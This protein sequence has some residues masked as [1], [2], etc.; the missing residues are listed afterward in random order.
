MLFIALLLP[1]GERSVRA[2]VNPTYVDDSP[3]ARQ[4]FQQAEEQVGSNVA[5]AVRSYQELLD[6]FGLRLLPAAARDGGSSDEFTSV[7]A[8]V[9]EILTHPQNRQ[10][11]ERY[12]TLESPQAERLL[13]A[14]QL[15]RLALTRPLTTPGLEAMLQLAQRELEAGRFHLARHHL[16]SAIEH[17]ELASTAE[18]ARRRAAHAWYM[19]GVASHYLRDTDQAEEAASELALIGDAEGLSAHLLEELGRL[20]ETDLPQE[21]TSVS[22][23]DVAPEADLG[24]LIAETIWSF[25][26]SEGLASRIET[27]ASSGSGRYSPR[28]APLLSDEGWTTTSAPTVVGDVVYVNQGHT[29][30]ALDRFTG[31]RIWSHDYIDRATPMI[32]DNEA[33]PPMDVNVVAVSGDSLVTLTGHAHTNMRSSDGRVICLD[34]QTGKLRWAARLDRLANASVAHDFAVDELEGLFPHGAPVIIDDIVL[35]E[36]RRVSRQALTSAYVVALDLR[37]GE[38]R[39]IRHIVSSGSIRR[40]ARPFSTLIFAPGEPASIIMA[41]AIGAVASIE[42]NSGEINWLHRYSVPLNPPVLEQSRKPW[43]LATPLVTHDHVIAIHAGHRRVGIYDRTTGG[44]LHQL[45]ASRQDTWNS[46]AYLLGDEQWVYAIGREIHAFRLGDFDSPAWVLQGTGT[47]DED[48]QLRG[49]VQLA[50]SALIVPIADSVL[51]VDRYTGEVEHHLPLPRE[52]VTGNPVAM[53]R[54]LVIAGSR[55][56]GAF[57]SLRE[58]ERMLRERIA[59]SPTSPDPALSLAQLALRADD[60]ALCMEAARMVTKSIELAGSRLSV[61]EAEHAADR[62]VDILLELDAKN[63]AAN[64]ADIDQL[65]AAIRSAARTPQHHLVHRLA[66]GDRLLSRSEVMRALDA[67]QEVLSNPALATELVSE[68]AIIRPGRDW[69]LQRIAQ[70]IAS[71]AN[72][73]EPYAALARDRLAE[74][75]RANAEVDGLLALAREYPFS[76]S[77]ADALLS[78]SQLLADQDQPQRALSVLRTLPEPAAPP[79]NLS[80]LDGA[81]QRGPHARLL[82]QYTALAEEL[83]LD[84]RAAAARASMN[85]SVGGASPRL[86]RIGP[87][88]GEAQLLTGRL[89]TT[90]AAARADSIRPA[91][92]LALILNPE[93]SEITMHGPGSRSDGIEELWRVQLSDSEPMLVRFDEDAVLMVLSAGNTMADTFA[94]MLD[95]ATGDERWRTPHL[96][97]VFDDV[98][99]WPPSRGRASQDG[100]DSDSSQVTTLADESVLVLATPTGHAAGF[101]IASGSLRWQAKLPLEQL[102]HAQLRG[103]LLA[104]TGSARDSRNRSIHALLALDAA[105]GAPILPRPLSLGESRSAGAIWMELDAN[106]QVIYGTSEGIHSVNLWRGEH[107]WINTWAEVGGSPRGWLRGD[108]LLFENGF[109]E[110]QTLDVRTG[111]PDEAF[112]LPDRDVL[113]RD[114]LMSAE[115]VGEGPRDVLAH[116]RQRIVRFGLDGSVRGADVVRDERNF[117]WL[118]HGRAGTEFDG[119]AVND[120]VLVLI[121]ALQPTQGM[122]A[123]P[124]SQRLGRRTQHPYRIYLLSENARI[125]GEPI[126]LPPLPEPIREARLIDGWLLLSLSESSIAA[127]MPL[128]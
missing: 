15:D 49:R 104:L 112:E 125:L 107:D 48:F 61:N 12:R 4:L 17:P 42:P 25:D 115:L 92:N 87:P 11:L 124:G 64:G 84:A 44:L 21:R 88:A 28:S 66:Y 40:A 111:Q 53:E 2:Q 78:A 121:N 58:A 30:T 75:R 6:D 102:H 81:E 50:E 5:E 69:A 71:A 77:A 26:L 80:A 60:F 1:I 103:G 72:A 120:E 97:E 79:P 94:I 101:H 116:Y 37:S 27:L 118:L 16:R 31:V 8:A 70:V 43:E 106:G 56:L 7:R 59:A 108:R 45:D 34:A 109:K 62:L 105:T 98:S 95:A 46:P 99:S 110:L 65:F 54:Q 86:P 73:Y 93:T 127:P 113:G 63:L 14:G 114:Q 22:S 3:L 57:M 35:V 23:L 91:T 39:W 13:A 41:S 55:T 29:I 24:E 83:G 32:V 18:A 20:R 90:V 96:G 85:A 126:E 100:G 9:M 51:I 128:Q 47:S 76:D 117:R 119:A 52:G 67:W 74:L 123:A 89:L 10:L 38:L 122:F 82:A 68:D 36:A 19:L 33:E